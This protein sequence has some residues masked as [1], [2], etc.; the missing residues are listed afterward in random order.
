MSA[1]RVSEWPFVRRFLIAAPTQRHVPTHL[2]VELML[3]V[4]R[5]GKWPKVNEAK[6]VRSVS[7]VIVLELRVL[8][9]ESNLARFRQR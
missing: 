6:G 4:D 9:A 7:R 5:I 8:R 3:P 2:R 1:R